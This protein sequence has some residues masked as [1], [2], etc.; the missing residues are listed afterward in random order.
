[1]QC[2]KIVNGKRNSV[3]LPSI[4]HIRNK[5]CA[6]EVFEC[7]NGVSP[8]NYENNFKRFNSLQ[9]HSWKQS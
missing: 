8:P 2:L 5:T 3:K 1:M 4:N 6:I 9:R 7:L